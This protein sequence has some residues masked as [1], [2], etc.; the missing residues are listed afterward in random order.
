M[1]FATIDI[2]TN[3]MRLLIADYKDNKLYNREKF[4]NITRIGKGVDKD[5]NLSPKAI[6]DNILS[7]KE[8]VQIAKDKHCEKIKVIGTSALRD[9][10]NKD[11][12]IEKA[13]K[14]AGVTVNII[15]G[16][17][18]AR[19]G[20]F[21]VKNLL[22]RDDYNL[23]L[24]I[25]G[26][27]TEFTLAH[28]DKEVI[29]NKSENIGAV[30]L[31]ER[32]I[33][34]HP[35]D[36]NTLVQLDKMIELNIQDT[37]EILKTYKISKIIA[38]GGTASS[39]SAII[40]ELEPYDSDKIHESIIT[41]EELLSQYNTLKTKTLEQKQMIKGLQPQRADVILT[42]VAILKKILEMLDMD[43]VIVSEYD[44][45]EGLIFSLV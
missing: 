37:I 1:K 33:T 21:G 35:P 28:S 7:L 22:D 29:F 10:K 20:F 43:K 26:G 32:L 11:V 31:T 16:D 15:G 24:D 9:S 25:G 8:Y 3:S 4:V 12:F 45:L 17:E 41:Y 19:L 5:G 34:A 38:I 39:I 36:V 27:S 18:E 44:N 30:R 14:Y 42:G 40:Q 6:D 23:I 13:G 2:G